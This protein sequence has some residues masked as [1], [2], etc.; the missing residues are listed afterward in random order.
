MIFNIYDLDSPLLQKVRYLGTFEK[1][2]YGCCLLIV[3]SF[4]L[5]QGCLFGLDVIEGFSLV[6]LL[7]RV[8]E[9]SSRDFQSF[10]RQKCNFCQNIPIMVHDLFFD[11]CS[12]LCKDL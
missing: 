5:P 9:I 10:S 7:S 3:I 6:D 4:Y 12:N 8:A 11:G 2:S 1:M